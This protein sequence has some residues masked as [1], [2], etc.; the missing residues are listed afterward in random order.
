MYDKNGDNKITLD[1]FGDVI[2]NLGLNPTKDQLGTLMQEIDLDGGRQ[3][4][5]YIFNWVYLKEPSFFFSS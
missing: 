1:E 4:E 5:P 2:K 3:T